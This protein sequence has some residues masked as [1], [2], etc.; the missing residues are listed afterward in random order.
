MHVVQ[1]LDKTLERTSASVEIIRMGP[2]E[3]EGSATE[4]GVGGQRGE[5]GFD[6][7]G[8]AHA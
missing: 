4:R 2:G 1:E 3:R 6:E 5:G 7:H 8:R